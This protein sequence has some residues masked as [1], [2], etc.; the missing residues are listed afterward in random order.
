MDQINKWMSLLTNVG[1]LVG[2]ALLVVELDQNADLVRA[3]IHAIRAEAKA[4]R[5]MD[6]ANSGEIS[7]IASTAF[8]AGFPKKTEGLDALNA[9][10]RFRF[11][12][13]LEG[14]KEAMGNWHYQCP[15]GLLDDELCQSS[16]RTEIVKLVSML[17]GMD[18]GLGNMRSSFMADVRNIAIEEG[19]PV[20]KK[21]GSW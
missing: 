9:E 8:A 20:P 1:V 3:E 14:L 11:T 18:I 6:L 5:Q 19:L 21:D 10:D 2:I 7:R 15:Q 16:Y 4:G 17:H 13:F 12:V